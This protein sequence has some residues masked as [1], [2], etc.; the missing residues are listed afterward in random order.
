MAGGWKIPAQAAARY[1]A[2]AAVLIAGFLL[3]GP[4]REAH[5]AALG[6]VLKWFLCAFSQ[7][8]EIET[9]ALVILIVFTH[10][11]IVRQARPIRAAAVLVAAF[12]ATALVIVPLKWLASRGP[13]GVFYLFGRMGEEGIMF[14]SGH[15]ALAFAA[16]A[17]IASVWRE[18][19]WPVWV[20]AVGVAVARVILVHFLSD[21][22]AGAVVGAAVGQGVAGLAV[23]AGF[24]EGEA[25]KKLKVQN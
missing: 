20:V 24:I 22:V 19:R 14:P 2:L 16:C 18:A 7:V 13:D 12:A 5:A 6:P 25:K 8:G 11:L 9:L 1:F 23:K 17:V 10:G 4:A 21:V 3:D 15:A